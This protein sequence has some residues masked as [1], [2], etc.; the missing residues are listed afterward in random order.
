MRLHNTLTGE[1]Q[2]FVPAA[3]KVVK[4]Y[5]CGVTPYAATHIGHALSY[6]VFD[7]LRRYLEYLGYQ[8]KHVQNFTDV[9]EKIIL[10]A[11]ELGISEEQLT[12]RYIDEFFRS[13]D[14]LSAQRAPFLPPGYPGNPWHHRFYPGPDR[15]RL[16]LPGRWRRLLSCGEE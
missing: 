9:D 16:R 11:R 4:M 3:D 6:I 10:R 14:A 7:V 5:V 15:E 12:E 2:E 1:E 8:V 13:M